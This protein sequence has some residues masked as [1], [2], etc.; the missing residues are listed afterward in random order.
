[1]APFRGHLTGN[2]RGGDLVAGFEQADA[3]G[4]VGAVAV[5]DVSREYPGEGVPVDVVGLVDDE[6]LD[7]EEVDTRR[8]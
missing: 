4:A 3:F 8:D 6:L 1:M 5:L 7:R 2:G